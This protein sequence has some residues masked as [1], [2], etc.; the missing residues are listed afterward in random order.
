MN[1][2]KLTR[3]E[4]HKAASLVA[5]GAATGLAGRAIAAQTKAQPKM[6]PK[7]VLGYNPKMPF[8][9]G[10]EEHVRSVKDFYG[11]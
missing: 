9:Q 6:D 7:K 3:R 1:E 5:A 4:F 10:L 2:E 8:I 11:L